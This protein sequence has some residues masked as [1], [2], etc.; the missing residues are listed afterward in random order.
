MVADDRSKARVERDDCS[1]TDRY[2]GRAAGHQVMIPRAVV[3]LIV[4]DRPDYGKMVEGFCELR[5][6]VAEVN[7]GNCSRD[8]SE[9]S[10]NLGRG[11]RLW[12]ESFVMR[13]TA[14]QPNE[15]AAGVGR[16]RCAG[17]QLQHAAE[18][19]PAEGSETGLDKVAAA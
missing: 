12:V 11:V 18:S 7:A 16:S 15:D 6:F 13:R 14:I 4:R 17:A 1:A 3:V 2:R 8:G 10:S 9:F 5:K 19:E